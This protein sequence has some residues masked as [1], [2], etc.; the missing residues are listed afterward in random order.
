[1]RATLAT[2]AALALLVVAC[3]GSVRSDWTGRIVVAGNGALVLFEPGES[4]TL[5]TPT[6]ISFV[7]AAT[8]S[9]DGTSL[10]VARFRL[11]E[12]GGSRSTFTVGDLWLLRPETAEP[13]I[14]LEHARLGE[15]LLDPSWSNERL[16]VAS[17]FPII[18]ND[19]YIGQGNEVLL[20]DPTTG[21][22]ELVAENAMQPGASGDGRLVAYV[23]IDPK[24]FEEEVRVIDL[25]SGNVRSMLEDRPELTFVRRPTPSPDGRRLLFSAAGRVATKAPGQ[26]PWWNPLIPRIAEAHGPLQDIWMI[27]LET[28]E[29]TQLTDLLEDEPSA[30]WSTDGSFVAVQG[31]TGIYLIDTDT[32]AIEKIADQG[33]IGT[34]AWWQ[35]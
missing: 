18:E 26:T 27:D 30:A 20:I 11:P 24:T 21:E 2:V 28:G 13:E 15:I 32:L 16:L 19:R 23:S 29:L 3:G 10:I 31:T 14:L 1:M 17:S 9:R 35:P 5:L 34:I 12:P 7:Q 22:R 33:G 8:F 4:R 6:G 25:E